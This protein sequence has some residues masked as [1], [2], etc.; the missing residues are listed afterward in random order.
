MKRHHAT[1]GPALAAASIVLM[2]VVGP[3]AW[4]QS[5]VDLHGWAGT[6]YRLRSTDGASDQD[7]YQYLN[8]DLNNDRAQ[9]SGHF[10]GRITADIDGRQDNE[11]YYPFASVYD[12]RDQ[13]VYGNLYS[14][15]LDLNQVPGVK[16][17][18]LGRQSM[19]D[20]PVFLHFDGVMIESREWKEAAALA[21]G[22]Y[23]GSPSRFFESDNENDVVYGAWVQ[24]RPWAGARVRADYAHVDDDNLYGEQN[25][26][27]VALSA[28]QQLGP[29]ARVHAFYS[30]LEDQN[31]DLQLDAVYYNP[32][33]DFMVMAS[34]YELLETQ[35][36]QSIDFDPFY[37]ALFEYYPYWQGR[38][39]ATKGI[40]E[41]FYVE[42]GADLR[43]LKDDADAGNFNHEF[44]RYFGTLGMRDRESGL[45]ASLTGEVWDSE[46]QLERIESLS[47][48]VSY[49]PDKNF[50]ISAGSYYALY[51]FDYYLSEEKERVQTYYTRLRYSPTE[52]LSLDG[53]YE[54]E[55]GE[56]DDFQTVKLGFRYS[57]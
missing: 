31:R 21:L 6:Q 3:A 43:Q 17:V 50:K 41:M 27:F 51:K 10:F 16:K 37:A 53:S 49:A 8:V 45:A 33:M 1:I 14:A 55:D 29:Y 19:Y 22:A 30:R 56:Y 12:T 9:V 34:Y 42:G 35:K 23:G 48:D 47:G 52:V 46:D 39:I 40:G 38:V 54:Y 57:F 24:A 18:R 4:A 36:I 25:D 5:S 44:V 13:S 26:D 32:E 20:A 7:I 2:L 28:W 15:Y 11:A